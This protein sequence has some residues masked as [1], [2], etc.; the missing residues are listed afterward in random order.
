MSGPD[1]TVCQ[2]WRLSSNE[3]PVVPHEKEGSNN[4]S[5]KA[6]GQTKEIQCG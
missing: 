4:K 6:C 5:Y 1:R 3:T 2:N